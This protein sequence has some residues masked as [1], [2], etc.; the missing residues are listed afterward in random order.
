MTTAAALGLAYA[1]S[2]RVVEALPVLEDGEAQALEVQI[3]DT[4]TATTALGAGYL[5][6]GK[7][8]EAARLASRVAELAAERGFRGHQARVSQLLGEICARRDPSDMAGAEEHYRRALALADE[9]GM[10]P[11]AAQ[12]HLGLGKLYHRTGDRAKAD[13]HV[14]T[15]TTMYREMDM[16]F[17]LEQAEAAMGPP[18]GNSP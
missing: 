1:L 12:C 10:R 7:F 4:S 2:G 18:H 16:T 5:L 3:F 8:D 9:L 14:A 11:L 13:E 15:A 17:W 6:A